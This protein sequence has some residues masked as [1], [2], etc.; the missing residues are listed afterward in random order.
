MWSLLVSYC[1]E[2]DAG[3]LHWVLW[4][5]HDS[6]VV[7]PAIE[8]GIWGPAYREVPFKEVIL[9]KEI[10]VILCTY[11]V[12]SVRSDNTDSDVS[13]GELPPQLFVGLLV[14]SYF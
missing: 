12:T 13:C 4:G 3:W 10:N 7:N 14:N 9:Q 5:K 6:A 11:S 1:E 8:I 2:D